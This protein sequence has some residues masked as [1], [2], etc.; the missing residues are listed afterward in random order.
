MRHFCLHF[1]SC[2]FTFYFA[3]GV[4]FPGTDHIDQWNKIIGKLKKTRKKIQ[5]KL[6]HNR[7]KLSKINPFF[8][9]NNSELQLQISW[10]VY[11]LQCA[12][13]L[14]IVQDM[15]VCLHFSAVC[16]HFSAICLHIC[17]FTGYSFERLFPD[18]L[19]PAESTDS[20]RLRGKL[21]SV[22]NAIFPFF[23]VEMVIL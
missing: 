5:I 23:A 22:K 6:V 19:F 9:Q 3:G 12:I 13:M 15:Q 7:L 16:L 18:V 8:S 4:L 2:L 17:F 20:N 21:K 11:N 14:K 10:N 1:F